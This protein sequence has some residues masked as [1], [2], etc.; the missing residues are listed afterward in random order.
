MDVEN[1]FHVEVT[2]DN[3]VHVIQKIIK[4]MSIE[5][6]IIEFNKMS[7]EHMQVQQEKQ[8]LQEYIDNEEAD[9]N[10]KALIE[11]DKTLVELRNMW[12]EKTKPLLEDIKKK[13]KRDIKKEKIKRGY[14]R[15]TDTN[16]KIVERSSILGHV[17]IEH[18]LDV[19]HP[20]IAEFRKDFD[21]IQWGIIMEIEHLKHRKPSTKR[22]ISA[23][24]NE[25]SYQF[26]KQ[27]NINMTRF[28]EDAIKKLRNE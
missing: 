1:K 20:I 25:T 27:N 5:E 23:K 17:V 7:Q 4:T 3:K 26:L 11:N 8:K 28:I 18:N 2:D 6:S 21:K 15:V 16:K 14:D 13:V 9:K 10:M 22:M 24:I 19:T 12:E